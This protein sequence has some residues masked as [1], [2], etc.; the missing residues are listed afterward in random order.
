[1]A[2]PVVSAAPSF[3]IGRSRATSPDAEMFASQ[4]RMTPARYCLPGKPTEVLEDAC[5]TRWPGS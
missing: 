4:A 5:R 2:A 1:M 3:Q